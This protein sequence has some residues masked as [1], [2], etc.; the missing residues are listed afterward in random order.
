METRS[1][2]TPKSKR[3]VWLW[4]SIGLSLLFLFF[5][6]TYFGYQIW[7]GLR[8]SLSEAADKSKLRN[9]DFEIQND[10][11]SILLIGTDARTPKIQDGRADVLIVAV[12]NPK[13]KSIFTT[14]IPRDTYVKIAN[15]DLSTK[16]NA[17]GYWGYQKGLNPNENIKETVEDLLQIPIDYYARINFQGFTNVV[18]T[19][20]GV[21]V[22]IKYPFKELA[23]GGQTVTF[24]TGPSHLDGAQALAYVRNRKNDHSG[25]HGENLGDHG[26]NIRQQKILTQII[27]K[28]ISFN[29][30]TKIVEISKIV[31]QNLRYN[32]QLSDIPSLITVYKKCTRHEMIKINTYTDIS[33][34]Y[35]E[36]M[37]EKEKKRVRSILQHQLEYLPKRGIHD[38]PFYESARHAHKAKA[39]RKR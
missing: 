20:G 8:Q 5:C 9:H 34:N 30:M 23:I 28:I 7:N 6:S 21:D 10:P 38:V 15:V 19:L 35:Y 31:G 12:V 14:S 3:K 22:N 25:P 33:G 24:Q 18:N 26:R 1:T 37:S 2:R 17:S 29:G 27:D 32:V 13:K 11:F 36:I 16:I 39:N 4:R